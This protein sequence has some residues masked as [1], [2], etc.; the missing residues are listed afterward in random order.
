[1]K[2][3]PNYDDKP[4]DLLRPDVVVALQ[5]FVQQLEH[6]EGAAGHR[7]CDQ[8]LAGVVE[9]DLNG[10]AEKGETPRKGS[11]KAVDGPGRAVKRR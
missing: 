11:G 6:L 2:L 5:A 8:Q 9:L 7:G 10:S 4:V 3:P 1:M